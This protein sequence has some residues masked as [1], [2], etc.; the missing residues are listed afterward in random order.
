MTQLEDSR[1]IASQKSIWG[2]IEAY[3]EAIFYGPVKRYA[4]P[5]YWVTKWWYDWLSR[6]QYSSSSPDKL[7][8][9]RILYLIFVTSIIIFLVSKFILGLQ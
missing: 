5:V 1:P 4:P 8:L 3:T 6:P 9:S 2:R 7:S